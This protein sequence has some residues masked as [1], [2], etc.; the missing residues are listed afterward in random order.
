M[1][2]VCACML[3][4]IVNAEPGLDTAPSTSYPQLQLT[5][6]ADWQIPRMRLLMFVLSQLITAFSP[7]PQTVTL[8]FSQSRQMTM[9]WHFGTGGPSCFI[10]RM[11]WNKQYSTLMICHQNWKNPINIIEFR[12]NMWRQH[13]AI[14]W[15]LRRHEWPYLCLGL[16]LDKSL[17]EFTFWR[18]EAFKHW[19]NGFVN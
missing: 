19:F 11:K 15:M 16:I 4:V 10:L 7:P 5:T 13:S 3:E 8:V 1:A 2:G 6:D 17:S 12:F 9:R 14:S 18:Q